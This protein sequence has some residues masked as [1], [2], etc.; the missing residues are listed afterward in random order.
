MEDPD[1]R[2][3]I[4]ERVCEGCG[5]CSV[6]SN[7]LSVQPIE[8]TFG[9]KRKIDQSSCNK[10]YS[11]A[12]GF[13]P[14]FVSVHG[15]K[16]KKSATAFQAKELIQPLPDPT[17]PSLEKPYSIFLTGVGGTGVVTI[18]AILGMAS[19]LEGKGCSIVDM[20]GL[21]Q[22]G[23]AVVSHIRI[24]RKSEDIHATRVYMGEA[25]L[26]FGCD[27]VVTGNP[28]SLNKIKKGKTKV[29]VNKDQSITGHFVHNPD[30]EFHH[31]A[32]KKDILAA[33]GKEHVDFIDAHRIATGLLGDAI[34][35]NM[36]MTG[37]AYQKGLIPLSHEAIEKTIEMNGVDVPFNIQAFR[38]GRYGAIDLKAVE[39]AA[40]MN[41][42]DKLHQGP[43]SL[44]DMVAHRKK[45]LTGYQNKAYADRYE[46]L[47]NRVRVADLKVKRGELSLSVAKYYAKLLA[48]KDEYEV[49][50]LYTDGV[51]LKELRAQFEGPVKLNFYLAPPLLARKD[52]LTGQLQKKTYGSW[53]M[54]TFRIL[55]KL[56]GLRGTV[57]DIFGHTADRKKERALIKAYEDQIDYLLENL[58]PENY[59]IAVSLASLPE[60][61]RGYGHVKDRHMKDVRVNEEVLLA[62]FKEKV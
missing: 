35:T 31:E 1:K 47:I 12:K 23:G 21:A 25:D 41:V 19:H 17:P 36:F 51:F 58:N 34:G 28:D 18:G 38:W 61:I 46:A 15:G 54:H 40:G 57:F 42:E 49:A 20:T 39:T 2:I 62:Q 10:D 4:N 7:C 59:E 55:A 43:L 50:R 52:P 45:F 6:K 14:S 32:L 37:Y 30:Y 8:T 9:R 53:M 60:H 56:K 22:K 29:L 16:L 44:E 13:C 5:D 11:C 27:I 33:A 3:F 26:I 24:A 48:V